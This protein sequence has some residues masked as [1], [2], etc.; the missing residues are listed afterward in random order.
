MVLRYP[1]MHP[2]GEKEWLFIIYRGKPVGRRFVQMV[3]KTS[4]MEN[5]VRDRHVPFVQ[6]T[7]IYRESGRQKANR[8]QFL[9]IPVGNF[10]LPLKTFRLFWKFSGR[11][12]RNGLTV[13][14]LTEISGFFSKW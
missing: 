4:Q 11:A 10:G 14:S 3:S 8:T 7:L 12:N 1:F 6:F 9:D 13:Y 5:S 2:G